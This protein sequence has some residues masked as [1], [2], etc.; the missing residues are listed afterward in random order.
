[1]QLQKLA[2]EIDQIFQYSAQE[3]LQSMDYIQ[4]NATIQN[5]KGKINRLVQQLPPEA[6]ANSTCPPMS[7][8]KV[9]AIDLLLQL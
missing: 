1:V 5:F 7:L 3:T 4:I 9:T 2:E 6:N 8:S